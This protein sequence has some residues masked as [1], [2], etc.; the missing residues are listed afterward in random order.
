MKQLALGIIGGLLLGLVVGFFTGTIYSPTSTQ[1][2]TTDQSQVIGIYFSPDGGCENAVITWINRANS[3]IHIL[4]YSFTLDSIG[5]ALLSAHERGLEIKTVFEKSQ[6]SQY[7]EYQRLRS[8]GV[9]VRNDTNPDYMHNKV[10]II[11]DKIVLTGSFNWSTNAQENNNENLIV[12]Q[13]TSA[14]NA[15]DNNF[16]TIWNESI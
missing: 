1:P 16:Q 14:A 5:N 2:V 3:T 12:I 4:I 6:I 13:S 8:A 7:S 9:N 11:D 15:F 10:M